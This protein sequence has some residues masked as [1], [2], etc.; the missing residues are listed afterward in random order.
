MILVFCLI[1]LW[2]VCCLL[3]YFLLIY[4]GSLS[5]LICWSVL[6]FYLVAM[7]M[8]CIQLLFRFIVLP[9]ILSPFPQSSL[10][11]SSPPIY[12]CSLSSFS[13]GATTPLI[14]PSPFKLSVF[15]HMQPTI[16]CFIPC[17][18]FSCVSLSFMIL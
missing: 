14:T 10:P 15:I 4:L 5:V 13:P 18:V 11:S 12:T 17:L 6:L 1:D 16:A 9:V 8:F 7:F 3:C 2:T